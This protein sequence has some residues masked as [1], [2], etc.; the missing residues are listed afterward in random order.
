MQNEMSNT[1]ATLTK[2]QL[3]EKTFEIL[4]ATGLNWTV[5]KSALYGP[6]GEKTKSFGIFRNDTDNWLGTVRERYTP[7]Q[8]HEMA[9]TIVQAS[10]GVDVPLT[11]GGELRGGGLIYLQ[12]QLPDEFIGKSA[13]KRYIT[14]LNSHDGTTAIGFG[15]S[16]T[17]VS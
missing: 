5:R 15:S 8:N 2:E 14:A 17:V 12:A 16:S 11:R 10:H 4:D 3:G 6:N 13:V 9:E 1:V 7:F